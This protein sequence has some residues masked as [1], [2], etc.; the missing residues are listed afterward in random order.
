MIIENRNLRK[1]IYP[2]DLVGICRSSLFLTVWIEKKFLQP[3]EE[4]KVPAPLFF[5]ILSSLGFL[6]VLKFI[7]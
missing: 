7:Y 1:N 4:T 3:R 2:T 6:C 5:K